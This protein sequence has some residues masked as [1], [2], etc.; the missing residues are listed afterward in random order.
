MYLFGMSNV[1]IKQ[2]SMLTY[3]ISLILEVQSSLPIHV[4]DDRYV[5]YVFVSIKKIIGSQII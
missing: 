1:N 3:I 5:H 4:N 2:A